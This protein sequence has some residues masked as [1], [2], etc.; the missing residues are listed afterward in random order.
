MH[1]I[2]I[3][4]VKLWE[5]NMVRVENR[6]R[7][8]I[9]QYRSK[10]LLKSKLTIYVDRRKTIRKLL[11]KCCK[12]IWDTYFHDDLK[13]PLFN[14]AKPASLSKPSMNF[15]LASTCGMKKEGPSAG[16]HMPLGQAPQASASIR[17]R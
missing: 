16:L 9:K 12:E 8:R 5:E 10:N 11:Y 6:F 17:K 2:A 13:A 3:S 15:Y 1:Y 14:A 7:Q 4:A